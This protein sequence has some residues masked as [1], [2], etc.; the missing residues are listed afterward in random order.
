MIRKTKLAARR[1]ESMKHGD[2]KVEASYRLVST[3]TRKTSC[4]ST[5]HKEVLNESLYL[6]P[7]FILS[8]EITAFGFQ[9]NCVWGYLNNQRRVCLL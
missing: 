5:Q 7:L 3:E 8:I 4:S 9:T 1:A 6:M 2:H